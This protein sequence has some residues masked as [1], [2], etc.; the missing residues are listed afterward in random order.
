MCAAAGDTLT[1]EF[2]S[3]GPA[4]DGADEL[5]MGG[6]ELEWMPAPACQRE[7]VLLTEPSGVLTDGTPRTL[8]YAPFVDCTWRI[9]PGLGRG[10]VTLVVEDLRSHADD[11][12]LY[13]YAGNN[14]DSAHLLKRFTGLYLQDVGPQ[15]AYNPK[16]FENLALCFIISLGISVALF[17]ITVA[18]YVPRQTLNILFFNQLKFA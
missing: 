7:P 12:I 2:V 9:A 13:I 10:P 16:I 17:F 14:N 6:W 8:P 11:D 4:D 3:G 18:R 1:V 15:S 5:S